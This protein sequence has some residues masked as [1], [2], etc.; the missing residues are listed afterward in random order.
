M[1]ALVLHPFD[2]HA[3]V[4]LHRD[5]TVPHREVAGLQRAGQ[6]FT[7]YIA[8]GWTDPSGL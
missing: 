3:V 6:G 5:V 1:T 2:R 4:D 7:R 8:L